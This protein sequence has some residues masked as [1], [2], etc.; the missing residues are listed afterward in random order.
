MV[1]L[2]EINC[3]SKLELL[4]EERK[5]YEELKPT[6][7]YQFPNRKPQESAKNYRT[8]NIKILKEK[9]KDYREKNKEI[10][11]EKRK[12]YTKKQ[13]TEKYREK[14]KCDCGCYIARDG[15]I[16]HLQTNKHKKNMLL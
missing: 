8:K 3:N 4:G 5:F 14:V 10:I 7:N 15:L 13:N 2:K 16:K 12:N 9:S 6:L 1:L 11:K